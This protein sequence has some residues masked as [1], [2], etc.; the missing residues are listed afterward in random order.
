MA[1]ALQVESSTPSTTPS[2]TRSATQADDQEQLLGQAEAPA[3]RRH[4][5]AHRS[6]RISRGPHARGVHRRHRDPAKAVAQLVKAVRF[7][8]P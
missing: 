5:P 3:S 7:S 1:Q 4:T 6:G 2:T 8:A